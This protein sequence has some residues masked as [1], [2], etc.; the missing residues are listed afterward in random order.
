MRDRGGYILHVD[1]TC[2]E[3]SGVLLVCLDSLSGQVL[4]SRKISSENHKEVKRVLKD[5]RRDWGWPL[6]IVHDMRRSLI[7]AAGEVFKGTP[8]FVCHF[9][10]AADVGKDILS[11]HVDRLRKLFRR[12]K[13]RPKLYALVRSVKKYALCQENGEH[14]V[15][16]LLD[17]RSSKKLREHCTPEAAK[18]AAHVLAS[19]I[20]A[21]SQDGDGYGF[22]FDLP[23]LNFYKRIL[24]VH[25]MLSRSNELCP[26]SNRKRGPLGPLNRLQRILN[27]VVKGEASGEFQE[28]VAEMKRDLRIFD[29]LR[30]RLRICPKGGKER[31]NDEGSVKPLGPRAHRSLLKKLR[32]SLQEQGRRN[33]ASKRAS[34]IVVD[35]LDKYWE[36]LFGH[37]VKIDS[38]KIVVPRTNNVEEGLFRTIKRQCRR[39]HGRGHLCRDIETMSPATPLVLNLCNPSYYETVYGGNDPEKIAQ[40]FSAVDA[41]KPAR[42]LKKWRQEKWS[43]KMPRKFERQKNLP[44]KLERFISFAMKE[45][46]QK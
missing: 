10:F 42:L 36:Y 23:Y 14:V 17:L 4:E 7:T 34:K 21:Y 25:E 12:T 41:T 22:P 13:I 32:D 1:G 24:R 20:L 31:R 15:S 3:G 6:A 29:R 37:V 8:Q 38:R 2:E 35:H 27:I 5:V 46:R 28:I 18:G 40:R 43:K 39:L 44:Q 16:S 30:S 26:K 33:P 9:H 19:W 45:L 11:P